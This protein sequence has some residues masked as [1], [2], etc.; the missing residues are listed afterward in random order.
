MK[1]INITDFKIVVENK[2]YYL[3]S[4]ISGNFF[5]Q[6]EYNQIKTCRLIDW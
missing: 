5:A 3:L 2:E 1:N 6:K 4:T